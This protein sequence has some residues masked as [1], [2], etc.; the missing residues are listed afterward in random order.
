VQLC[1][2]ENVTQVENLTLLKFAYGYTDKV[3][4][5]AKNFVCYKNIGLIQLWK[6]Y[7]DQDSTKTNMK[8]CFERK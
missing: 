7:S 5:Y 1:S 8:K 4:T 6:R 2:C 3:I